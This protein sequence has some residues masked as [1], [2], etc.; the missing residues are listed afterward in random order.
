MGSGAMIV[1]GEGTCLVTTLDVLTH[2]YAHESCGQCTPCREGTG[3]MA[4]ITGRIV[5]GEG[6]IEDLDLLM[7]IATNMSGNTICPLAD[8]SAGPVKSFIPKFRDEFETYI[9]ER[10][11]KNDN[12]YPVR[13][14]K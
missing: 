9:R 10:K 4:A 14:K 3:W 13:W 5:R 7:S 1:I 6:A 12:P 11:S 2:F 8:A